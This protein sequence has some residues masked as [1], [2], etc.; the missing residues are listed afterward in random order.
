MNI[1]NILCF[2]FLLLVLGANFGFDVLANQVDVCVGGKG[3]KKTKYPKVW[4]LTIPTQ[5]ICW[6]H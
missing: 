6:F 1:V 3:A 2:P 5:D 4:S